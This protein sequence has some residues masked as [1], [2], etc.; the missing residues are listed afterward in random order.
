M[1]D[2][3]HSDGLAKSAEATVAKRYGICL[4]RVLE[5]KSVIEDFRMHSLGGIKVGL[6]IFNS[7]ILSTLIYNADTWFELNDGTIKRLENIQNILLRCLLSVP[8]STPITALNWDCGFLSVEYRV[9]QKKLMFLHYLINLD[10]SSLANEIFE[11]QKDYNLPGFVQEGR[12]L[13]RKFS[14]PNIIDD[15]I[16]FSKCQWKRLVKSSVYDNYEDYL[17]KKISASSKLKNGPMATETFEEKEYITN[18][19]LNDSR[20]LFRIRSKMTSVKMNQVSDK[21]NAMK[22]WKCNECGNIDT[23][24]HILWCP[25]FASIR[26]GKSVDNDSDLVEYFQE[27][28]KIREERKNCGL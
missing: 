17:K 20:T 9:Y 22:L 23:Q 24:S 19:T 8:N 26:D 18:M 2:Y 12:S 6:E 7:A 3:L 25:F 28:F 10:K 4:N 1:G 14:L 15:D 11:T 21:N 5:L 27:V 16:T 13:F